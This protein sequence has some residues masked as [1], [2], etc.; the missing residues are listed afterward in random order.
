MA[1]SVNLLAF[2]FAPLAPLVFCAGLLVSRRAA[3]HPQHP[4]ALVCTQ[5]I[6]SRCVSGIRW[7]FCRSP[8]AV[9]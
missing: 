4:G 5:C 3:Q 6:L 2:P 9:W 1:C 8:Q 7:R